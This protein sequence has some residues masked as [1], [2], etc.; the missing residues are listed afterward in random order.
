MAGC[1]R[2]PDLALLLRDIGSEFPDNPHFTGN[3]LRLRPFRIALCVYFTSKIKVMQPNSLLVAAGNFS[4]R[5]AYA[6]RGAGKAKARMR[7]GMD[8]LAMLAQ[9]VLEQDPFS[10]HLFVFRGRAANL[11]KIMFWDGNGLC[12]FT[13]LLKCD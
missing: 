4:S 12:L 3:S 13:K 10:G 7:K 9:K 5:T 11:I 2:S 1:V 6:K 8:G